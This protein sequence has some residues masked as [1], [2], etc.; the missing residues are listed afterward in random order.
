MDIKWRSDE[1]AT[2]QTDAAERRPVLCRTF[3]TCICVRTS[4]GSSSN[5]QCTA[6]LVN[7]YD[8]AAR[9]QVAAES[10]KCSS[11]KGSG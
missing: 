6:F 5:A 3:L 9:A 10:D 7:A 2:Q 1:A 8:A 11:S 4:G